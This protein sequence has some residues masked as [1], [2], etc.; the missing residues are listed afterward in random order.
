MS[1]NSV[2]FW[3]NPSLPLAR[4]QYTEDSL[5]L[6]VMLPLTVPGSKR[7]SVSEHRRRSDKLNAVMGHPLRGMDCTRTTTG[8]AVLENVVIGTVNDPETAS[9]GEVLNKQDAQFVAKVVASRVVEQQRSLAFP[10]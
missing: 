7:T 3:K 5:G 4:S 10:G 1:R 2:A 8:V 9:P 6:C